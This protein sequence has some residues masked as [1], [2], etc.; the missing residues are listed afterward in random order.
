MIPKDLL[1][2]ELEKLGV[3]CDSPMAD[4]FDTFAELLVEKNKELNLTAITDP[5]GIVIKH[6]VDSLSVLKYADFKAGDRVIDVGTGAGF[7]AI[8]LLIARPDIHV[9]MLDGTRKRLDFIDQVV[10]A[11]GLNGET[12]HLRAELAGKDTAHREQYDKAVSRAV[13]NLNTLSE[14][15]LPLVKVGGQFVA[16]K[17]SA[18]SEELQKAKGA[19]KLLGGQ[20][21]SEN[22]FTLTGDEGRNII[23][24]KKISQTSTKYPRPSAKISK[25][26][27]A[28]CRKTP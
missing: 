10:E 14:Y 2:V 8:P 23:V 17:G 28:Y 5:E 1:K 21:L 11:L 25:S 7:P 18:G 22:Q 19:I 13:A 3:S 26:P 24:V 16:M 4:R 27:L 9:T 12:L 6:F 15:C 20:V